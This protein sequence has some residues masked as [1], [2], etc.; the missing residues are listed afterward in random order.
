MKVLERVCGRASDLA[1]TRRDKLSIFLFQGFGFNVCENAIWRRL[2]VSMMF[3]LGT[4]S[5]LDFFEISTLS[6]LC[7]F[8][9]QLHRNAQSGDIK[10]L[11][12]FP[13]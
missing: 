4:Y 2:L 11:V 6:Y 12:D 8:Y 9:T 5:F 13:D 3:D 1:K 7:T 10:M